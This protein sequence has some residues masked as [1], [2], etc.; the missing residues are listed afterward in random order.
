[1]GAVAAAHLSLTDP[2]VD[3]TSVLTWT[4][5]PGL[6]TRL[7]DLRS[8][9]GDTLTRA[10]LDWA[11]EHAGS[12]ALALGPLLLTGAARDAVPLGLV[13][14]LRADAG[15]GRAAAR[16]IGEAGH[17]S[18]DAA[19]LAREALTRLD[20]RLGGSLPPTATL[21][22]WAREAATVVAGMLRDPTQ[23]T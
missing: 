14:A 8:L 13:T 9:A 16:S 7:V 18:A 10:V 21:R 5:D 17:S 20:P 6:V 3:A 19:Q 2:V 15:G 12:A 11:A 22:S 1:L 23:Q 4:T